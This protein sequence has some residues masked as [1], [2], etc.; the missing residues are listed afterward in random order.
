ML[1]SHYG[2]NQKIILRAIREMKLPIEYV[3]NFRL[4]SSTLLL[5]VLY[6]KGF[7]NELKDMLLLS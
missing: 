3:S 2:I 4:T 6:W 5:F 1:L 7:H